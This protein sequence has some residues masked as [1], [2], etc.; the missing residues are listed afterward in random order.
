MEVAVLPAASGS[1]T[2]QRGMSRPRE[3]PAQSPVNT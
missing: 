1:P 2:G 3:G